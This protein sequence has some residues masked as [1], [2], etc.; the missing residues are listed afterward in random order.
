VNNTAEG[1]TSVTSGALRLEAA[2]RDGDGGLA[3]VVLHPHPLYGGD[4]DNHVV[5]AI[6]DALAA[7]GAAT[8]RFN[9]RGAGRSDGAHDDGR[10]EASDARAAIA[11]LREAAPHA[12]LVVAGYSFGAMIA[13]SVAADASPA[14]LIL[15]SPPL[16]AGPLTELDPRLP[17]LLI[18]GGADQIA[19]AASLRGLAAGAVR[20]V[21]VEGADHAWWPGID[22]LVSEIVCFL[23]S[24]PS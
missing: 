6:C 17:T 12:R 18:T 14:A 16:R 15:V 20:A 21:E 3:A 7:R 23:D 5:I 2:I 10:G 22:S 1:R 8:L 11:L 24:L 19:P 9:F 4:M 13:A